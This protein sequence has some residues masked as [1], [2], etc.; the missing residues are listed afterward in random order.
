M[1]L[2]EK[3]ESTILAIFDSAAL[4]QFTKKIIISFGYIDFWPKILPCFKNPNIFPTSSYYN[5]SFEI[6]L[7]LPWRIFLRVNQMSHIWSSLEAWYIVV[8]SLQSTKLVI[9][10][11]GLKFP[12]Q[13]FLD[14]RQPIQTKLE[15]ICKAT[16]KM[17][18]CL[19]L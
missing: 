8:E 17:C 13:F 10:P 15:Y 18:I 16:G 19:R 11:I 1:F 14:A 9:W 3:I 5:L 6:K 4:P 12:V 7:G 2:T